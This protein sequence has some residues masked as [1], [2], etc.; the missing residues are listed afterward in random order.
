VK[1]LVA[2]TLKLYRTSPEGTECLG[3]FV[4]FQVAIAKLNEYAQNNPG[5]Y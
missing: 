2:D 1:L 4:D 3:I 5:H